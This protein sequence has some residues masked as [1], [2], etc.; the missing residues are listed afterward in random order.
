MFKFNLFKRKKSTRGGAAKL[1]GAN[2]PPT[3]KLVENQLEIIIGDILVR[4]TR[5]QDIP[6]NNELTAVIP[7]AEIRRRRYENG[8][9]AGAE[10]EIILTSITLVDAPR[11]PSGKT[12]SLTG[13]PA[14][15]VPALSGTP[16]PPRSTP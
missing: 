3:E 8:R 5:N 2:F 4:I 12:E 11:C 13:H 15:A 14:T 1:L 9:L 10:E 7:R 16:A 6:P